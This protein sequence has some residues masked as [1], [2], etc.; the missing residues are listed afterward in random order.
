MS[1]PGQLFMLSS[2]RAVIRLKVAAICIALDQGETKGTPFP[3]EETA[4]FEGFREAS[5][6]GGGVGASPTPPHAFA[7]IEPQGML[8]TAAIE[9]AEALCKDVDVSRLTPVLTRRNLRGEIDI[10]NTYLLSSEVMAWCAE[11]SM[12]YGPL[13]W[14]HDEGERQI[15]NAGRLGANKVREELESSKNT[16]EFIDRM[17]IA[18]AIEGTWEEKY[19]TLL[20]E[21][22]ANQN[23][24]P[25]E[26]EKPISSRERYSLMAIIA[27]LIGECNWDYR[28]AAK[29]ASE[30]YRSANLAGIQIGETTI[31]N[32]LKRIDAALNRES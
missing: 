16:K 5:S 10:S 3:S 28:R 25:E 2:N 13:C 6:T 32:H 4:P 18:R 27:T 11:H 21:Q 31:E 23:R 24:D 26:A 1:F 7:N 20:A 15:F 22:I 9:V 29:T 19:Q 12:S 8:R 14:A 30:I 17:S